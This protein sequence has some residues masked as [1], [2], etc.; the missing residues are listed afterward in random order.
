MASWS[1]ST[2]HVPC[3]I[4]DCQGCYDGSQGWEL[5]MTMSRIWQMAN[6]SPNTSLLIVRNLRDGNI[7]WIYETHVWF[8]LTYDEWMTFMTFMNCFNELFLNWPTL[9]TMWASEAVGAPKHLFPPAKRKL[10][11]LYPEA[12]RDPNDWWR[13]RVCRSH[14]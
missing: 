4:A 12:L 9:S 3:L 13:G 7:P 8:I 1:T 10:A 6:T 11:D 2:A 14:V 5:T